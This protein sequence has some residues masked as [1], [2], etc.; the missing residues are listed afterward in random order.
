VN[1]EVKT[2]RI[3]HPHN[4]VKEN[5]SNTV[6][7]LGY[8]DGVHLGHQEVINTAKYHARDKG[9]QCAVMTFDPHPSV[10][11]RGK[12]AVKYITPLED[13]I[14]QIE[15]LGIDLLYIIEF[16]E[17][18]ANLLPQEFVDQFIIGFNVKHVVAGFDFSYGRLGKG[19]METLPFHS[20]NQFTQ[21][22]VEK[23][24]E[25]DTKISSTLIREFIA[26]GE[27][28]EL[29]N[30]LG[31]YYLT[32]GKV[33]H[34]EKRGRKI[35]FPTA[36][37]QIAPDYISPP[38]GVYAV[39]IKI[40]SEWHIGVCNLGVKPTFHENK[41]IPSIEVHILDF[42][43]M[44]YDQPVAVKWYKRLRSEK[45]FNGIQELIMQIERDKVATIDYFENIREQACFLS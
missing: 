41:I 43:Q 30:Y 44:I 22:T 15:M 29:P 36:N 40:G 38:L 45:K 1:K 35:G 26:N 23:L 13:K 20:R 39:K 27:V 10:V 3:S 7:A 42:N 14:S 32:N 11:L 4:L 8:F 31:R 6:M 2:I 34:G 24:A 33:V 28:E 18:F 21:T 5:I 25:K 37:I 16:T 19:T 12:K 9:M 17:Q